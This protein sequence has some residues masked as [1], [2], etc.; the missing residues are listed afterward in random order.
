MPPSVAAF[1]RHGMRSS[2]N[3]AHS[4][5][6][7]EPRGQA[8]KRI[9]SMVVVGGLAVVYVVISIA[10]W[11]SGDGAAQ[12][13][14]KY[15]ALFG[16]T[17]A[18]VVALG[19]CTGPRIE[20]SS[21]PRVGHERGLNVTIVPGSTIGFVL[22]QAIWV[23]LAALFLT[24]AVQTAAAAWDTHW[25]LVLILA[26]VGLFSASEPALALAGRLRPGRIA[27][28]PSE[29]VHYGWSSRT[30]MPWADVLLVRPTFQQVPLI[31]VAGADS[32]GWTYRETAPHVTLGSKAFRIWRLDPAPVPLECPR[33]SVD[34][35][36]LYR[37]LAFYAEN[38]SA[39]TE[40]GTVSALEQWRAL[41]QTS[42]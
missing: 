3:G 39:R 19:F 37:Y 20:H 31:E 1:R 26:A 9:V 41:E 7:P 40:L 38:P 12:V 36:T 11:R 30:L 8:R 14:S 17:M 28:S 42:S 21:A 29:I 35:D 13:V 25:P 6:W 10:M 22:F 33:L 15:V 27:L 16:V 32:T 2:D 23:C 5:P 24:A 18:L 34:R 4:R